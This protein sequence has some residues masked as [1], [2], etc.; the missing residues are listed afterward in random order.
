M[1]I[2]LSHF[3][4]PCCC[5]WEWGNGLE[6]HR[7]EKRSRPFMVKN[8]ECR[9][10][11]F[12]IAKKLKGVSGHMENCKNCGGE[13]RGDVCENCYEDKEKISKTI[14]RLIFL[15]IACSLFP[16]GIFMTGQGLTPPF[17]GDYGGTP[18]LKESFY[19]YVVAGIGAVICDFIY[20]SIFFST[21]EAT[22]QS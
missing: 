5:R 12:F 14:H 21:E 4:C 16:L 11:G 13:I 9:R 1:K 18:Y 15:F 17:P 2:D 8:E 3:S 19:P 7:S 10:G 6:L 22:D 20:L